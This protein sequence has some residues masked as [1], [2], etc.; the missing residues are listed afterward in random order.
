MYPV[1]YLDD[2]NRG[3]VTPERIAETVHRLEED[4]TD[5]TTV[6][7]CWKVEFNIGEA[8][9]VDPGKKPRGSDPLMQTLRSNMLSLLN[10]EDWWPPE[11]VQIVN[12]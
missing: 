2:G 3:V 5:S 6:Q 10:I 1:D 7:P 4:L 8:I 9:A 11:P 12:E